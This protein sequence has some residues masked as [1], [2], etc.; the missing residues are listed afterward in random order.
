[1]F[2]KHL[3]SLDDP[4]GALVSQ[5]RFMF[6]TVNIYLLTFPISV[7]HHLKKASDSRDYSNDTL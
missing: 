6:L 7:H 3:I 1:M 4:C 5:L 2:L